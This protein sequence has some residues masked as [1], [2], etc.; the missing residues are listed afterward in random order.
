MAAN[1]IEPPCS[2]TAPGL[3]G[4]SVIVQSLSMIVPVPGLPPTVDPFVAFVPV[5]V[6]VKVLSSSGVP[7]ST[8]ATGTCIDVAPWF[9]WNEPL[10]PPA[11]AE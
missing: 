3:I 9:T 11:L 5:S 4:E 7:L 2:L 1:W 6:T 8:V 10:T